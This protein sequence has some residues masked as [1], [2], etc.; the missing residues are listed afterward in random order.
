VKI[1]LSFSIV[2]FVML[3]F[4]GC[5]SSHV[6]TLN[7]RRISYEE[8][9]EAVQHQQHAI[10]SL[11]GEG[12]I[13]VETPAIAQSG[14]FTLFLRKPDSVLV[15]L[16]GPFGIKVGF[17]LITRDEF[18]FYN[19]FENKLIRGASSEE[20]IHRILHV[21]LSFDDMLNLLGGGTFFEDDRR[22]PDDVRIEEEQ[23][24]FI[25]KHNDEQRTYW[26]DPTTSLIGKIQQCD[27]NGKLI[28][29]QRFSNFQSVDGTD[30]PFNIRI[31]QPRE[32]QMLSVVYSDVSLN[33][34]NWQFNFSIPSSAEQIRW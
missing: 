1:R 5:T 19:S 34:P 25:Y 30:V 11:Y 21:R 18:V 33:T 31:T 28:F 29:E 10:H 3:S 24:T 16:Q 22:T 13:S 27:T 14:S 7:L 15:K 26:I 4:V 23:W 2:A 20:N 9:Q 8:V 6:A 17:V 32:Q 12:K